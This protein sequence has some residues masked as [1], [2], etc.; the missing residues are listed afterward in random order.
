[1]V[2]TPACGV[3]GGGW[4]PCKHS[5]NH[6]DNT[7]IIGRAPCLPVFR[8]I[9]PLHDQRWSTWGTEVEGDSSQ[10]HL[11]GQEH[12]GV[13]GGQGSAL[14]SR[15]GCLPEGKQQGLLPS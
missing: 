15:L 9:L 2:V 6:S 14:A 1:M 10:G 13:L 8:H 5:I 7:W 3:K 11:A 12:P 4:A